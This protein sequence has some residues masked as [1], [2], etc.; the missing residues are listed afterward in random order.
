MLVALATAPP[1]VAARTLRAPGVAAGLGDPHGEVMCG[2]SDCTWRRSCCVVRPSFSP[3]RS[4]LQ[5]Q[6]MENLPLAGVRGPISAM[7]QAVAR[8]YAYDI[9]PD[10]R[11]ELLDRGRPPDPGTDA[12][13]GVLHLDD[14]DALRRR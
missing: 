6:R 11:L 8:G 14:A 3:S 9:Y 12:L 13:H 5:V 10:E 2:P 1:E 4:S 7:E